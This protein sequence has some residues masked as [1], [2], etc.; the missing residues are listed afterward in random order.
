MLGAMT[1]TLEIQE[2]HNVQQLREAVERA[3]AHF[4]NTLKAGHYDAI[5]FR[6]AAQFPAGRIMPYSVDM[7][8]CW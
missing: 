6:D 5:T 3:I 8:R 7:K 2:V 4:E 1:V